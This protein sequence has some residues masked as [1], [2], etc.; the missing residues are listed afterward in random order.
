MAA[1]RGG[2]WQWHLPAG[3]PGR[4]MQSLSPHASSPRD[5][6]RRDTC[7][8]CGLYTYIHS[9]TAPCRLPGAVFLVAASLL[10]SFCGVMQ[11]AFA[12]FPAESAKVLAA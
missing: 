4:A 1:G 3:I 6:P 2:S 12:A 7:L 5:H 9:P 10:L 11:H 8:R